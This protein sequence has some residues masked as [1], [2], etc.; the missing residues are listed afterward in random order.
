VGRKGFGG[1]QK[2]GLED[3]GGGGFGRREE[4]SEGEGGLVFR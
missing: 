2:V 3:V 4:V 1:E